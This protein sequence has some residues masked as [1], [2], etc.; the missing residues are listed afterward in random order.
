MDNA[1]LIK[2]LYKALAK[3]QKRPDWGGDNFPLLESLPA[4]FDLAGAQALEEDGESPFFPAMIVH[5]GNKFWI[6]HEG[7]W[8]P[9]E[10]HDENP[11]YPTITQ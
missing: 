6:S 7:G 1:K 3:A 11:G 4:D 2:A 9:Y 5:D 10:I 8:Y